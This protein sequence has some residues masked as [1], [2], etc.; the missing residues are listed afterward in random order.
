M[1]KRILPVITVLAL[2]ACSG[3][4]ATNNETQKKVMSFEE[5]AA[6]FPETQPENTFFCSDST[7]SPGSL[8]EIVAGDSAI[9]QLVPDILFQNGGYA[10]GSIHENDD[11]MMLIVL[12]KADKLGPL[13]IT[14]QKGKL[15]DYKVGFQNPGLDEGFHSE[16][17]CSFDAD[18]YLNF[19][20]ITHNWDP[21]DSAKTFKSDTIIKSTAPLFFGTFND[22]FQ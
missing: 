9:V 21:V 18:H 3:S 1:K 13:F 11:F 6:Q 16:E 8:K 20:D 2:Y 7:Y 14:Y 22:I 19:T 4:P 15:L 12:L 5:F 10:W 17:C